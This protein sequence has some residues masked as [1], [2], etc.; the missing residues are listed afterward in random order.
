[1]GSVHVCT[2]CVGVVVGTTVALVWWRALSPL[3]PLGFM[4]M[5][6]PGV[7]DFVVHEIGWSA[8]SSV[9]RFI[10]GVLF[11]P[12]L[13]ALIVAAAELQLARMALLLG[14]FLL[15]QLVSGLVLKRRG[16]LEPLL[17]RYEAGIYIEP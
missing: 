9:R 12:F 1:M 5:A 17:G 7:L 4:L 16:R 13:A 3:S 10:S 2:R 11:G 15:L 6:V 14:W 8:S